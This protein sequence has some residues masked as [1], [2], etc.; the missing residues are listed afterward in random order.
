MKTSLTESPFIANQRRNR[1]W[2]IRF[3][4]LIMLGLVFHYG[5]VEPVGT[6][7]FVVVLSF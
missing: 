5:S 2:L 4:L 3:T 6:E 7:E 1:I